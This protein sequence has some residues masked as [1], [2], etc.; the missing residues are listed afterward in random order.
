MTVRAQAAEGKLLTPGVKALLV[1]WALG[2]V[3]GLYRF[4]QGLG[5]ATSMNDGYPWGI[6]IAIDVVVGTGLASGGYVLAFLVFILNKGRYHPLVRPAL[7]TSLLGYGVA[8]VAVAFDLGRYWTMWRI[9]L[10]PHHWSSTSVLLEVALCMMAYVLVIFLELSPAWLEGLSASRNPQRAQLAARWLPRAEKA[11]PFLIAFGLLLPTMHQSSL[12]GLMM[13]AGHKLHPLWHSGFLPLYFLF[14]A[15]AMGFGVLFFESIFSSMAFGRPLE[16]RLLATLG[17]YVAGVILAFLAFRFVI[18]GVEG[19]LGLV[20]SSGR[21][22]FFFWAEVLVFLAAAVIFL[23]QG[24]LGRPE[25][26]L[27]AALL[28][29][30]GGTLYRIDVFLVAYDPGNG[31]IY[32]PSVA[33][34]LITLGLIATET[35]IYVLVVRKFPIL[36]GVTPAPR[37]EVPAGLKQGATP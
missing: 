10:S 27:Q 28:A 34:I 30:L 15:F 26:Q 4:T 12:G 16:N 14:T 2:T 24:L 36:A 29:M 13:M 25:Q 17:K 23:R 32:F 35:V 33:E 18:L 5:S 11:L 7:L 20:F 8:G 21:M 37:R 22:G 9:P 19:K 6:W 3:A 31:W 1:L